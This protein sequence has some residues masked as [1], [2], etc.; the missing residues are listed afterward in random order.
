MI[1]PTGGLIMDEVYFPRLFDE[2]LKFCLESVGAILIVGP[3]FCGK[4]TTA[5]R[6]AKTIIDLTSEKNQRQYI[7]LALNAPDEF[8]NQGEKPMLIDE[9][10]VISFIWNSIKEDVSKTRKFGQ[11][12]LTGSVTDYTKKEGQYGETHTGTGRILTKMLRTFSLFES[13]DSSG[14]VSIRDLKEGKFKI[15][16]SKKDIYDYAY[17]ICRGGWP[18]ALGQKENVALR[19]AKNFYSGA[20]NNDFFSLKDVPIRK[21]VQ[22][23]TKMMRSYARHIGS[24]ASDE[25]LRGDFGPDEEL[26]RTTFAKYLLA[27]KRLYIADELEAWNPN[28]RSKIAIRTKNTR[29]FVDPSIATAAF[30]LSPQSL[31]KDMKTFGFLFESLA[32]RDLK[33][34]CESLNA[35]LYHYRDKVGREVDAVIQFEDGDYALIEIKLCDE[36]ELDLAA[37]KLLAIANDIDEYKPKP[38]FIM[39]ITKNKFA[40]RREDGV[41]VV[42]LACLRN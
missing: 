8:L 10:Q 29:Y 2:E 3:K 20:I 36:L 9:W 28:L 26:D 35:N 30:G 22:K 27:M 40:Y 23:A 19:Q 34:Y 15:S 12:I 14:E 17:L 21:D 33:I 41:Y 31:F 4:S 32:I 24:Q 7:P 1:S 42:P 16:V 38:A 11:Y 39:I 37:E 5:S 13:G 18:L 25:E 6:Y